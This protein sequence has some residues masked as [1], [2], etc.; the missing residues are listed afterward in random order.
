MR[1]VQIVLITIA[2]TTANASQEHRATHSNAE[3]RSSKSEPRE[4]HFNVCESD[5]SGQPSVKSIAVGTTYFQ[6]RAIPQCYTQFPV[7]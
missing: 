1:L 7:R 5:L 3:L 4:F 6:F 2:V